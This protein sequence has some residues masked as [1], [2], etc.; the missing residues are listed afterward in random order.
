MTTVNKRAMRATRRDLLQKLGREIRALREDAGRSQ[1]AV[2]REA[3]IAGSYLSKIEAGG[4]EPSPTALLAVAAALGADLSIR[5][6]PNTGPRIRDRF[7]VAMTEALLAMLH[8]RW[9]ATPEVPVYRPVRGVID[10]VLED[11]GGADTV[12]TELHSRLQRVEQQL[13]WSVQKA[14]A[15][16]GRPDMAQRR[17]G[18]LLVVRNTAAMRDLVRAAPGTFAAAYPAPV[19]D[20]MDALAGTAPWPG[21]GLLWADVA[22]GVA[23]VLRAPPRGIGVGR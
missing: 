1:A 22:R 15:L 16:A 13:R 5:V 17:V 23:R 20:V 3:G 18:R 19:A 12:A 10:V 7:Q 21:P 11:R 14:D 9:Q 4:A 8:P 2:A 6:F